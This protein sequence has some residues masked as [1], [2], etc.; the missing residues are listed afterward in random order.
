MTQ[1]NQKRYTDIQPQFTERT[2]EGLKT[3]DP[4]SKLFENNIIM[5]AAPIDAATAANVIS[6][7]LVLSNKDPEQDISIYINSPGGEYEAALAIY[8]TMQF[9]PNPI[10]TL[11]VGEVTGVSA[12]ILAAGQQRMAL[13][14]ARITVS[15][16]EEGGERGQATDIAIRAELL[17]K[18]TANYIECLSNETGHSVE[19]LTETI[20][21]SLHMDP[22]Q[23]MEYG[24]LDT[25]SKP[26]KT[27]RGKK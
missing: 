23:A 12:L 4:F 21:R 16:F 6:Q 18:K 5:L 14:H 19:E 3:W 10:T 20:K 2:P 24:I 7:L 8:D 13:P 22:T 27:A 25:V 26:R 1:M 9:I 11:C 17:E 15:V